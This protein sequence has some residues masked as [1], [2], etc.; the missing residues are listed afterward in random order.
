VQQGCISGSWCFNLFLFFVF[1]PI[2]EE[3]SAL[4]VELRLF[5]KGGKD[6]D[7]HALFKLI[8]KGKHDQVFRLGALFIVD[9]TTLLSDSLDGLRAGLALVYKRLTAFGLLANALKSD[10]QCLAGA[11]SEPCLLCGKRA[12]ADKSWIVCDK[13]GRAAH[14]RGAVGCAGLDA[15]MLTR[16]GANQ[17][18]HCAICRDSEVVTAQR[19]DLRPH[20]PD[21]AFRPPVP[22]GDGLVAWAET[23]KY[24][25]VQVEASCGLAAELAARQKAARASFRKLQPLIAGGRLGRGE[26]GMF[27]RTF[28]SLVQ[29]VMLYGCV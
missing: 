28:S 12:G 11:W 15:E 21:P 19:D 6:L 22:F 1:E 29:T 16:T 8:A 25:G 14:R 20:A 13:C 17:E 24:L 4:G 26:T 10:V 27:A 3:L 5:D 23:I 9:D 2:M 18:W 7:H